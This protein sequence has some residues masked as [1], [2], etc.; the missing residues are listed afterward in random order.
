VGYIFG[1]NLE[2]AAATLGSVNG[3]AMIAVT[4]GVVVFLL[5]RRAKTRR[6]LRRA[7]TK[8]QDRVHE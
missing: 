7:G 5:V 8:S 4:V 3:W 1:A 6:L 2:R